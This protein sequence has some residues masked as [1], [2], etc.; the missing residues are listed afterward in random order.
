M[1]RTEINEI[2]KQFSS[3]RKMWT[4]KE[5]LFITVLNSF[6]VLSVKVD[7]NSQKIKLK[8]REVEENKKI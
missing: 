5:Q 2:N 4:R 3:R 1:I 7:K 8:H 6:G